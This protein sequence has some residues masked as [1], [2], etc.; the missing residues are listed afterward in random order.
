MKTKE[1]IKF[2]D[3]ENK[4][5]SEKLGFHNV[6][7]FSRAFSAIAGM[8]PGKWKINAKNEICEDIIFDPNFQNIL[9]ITSNSLN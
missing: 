4:E 5:I 9:R 2:S 6:H 7:Q 8:P 1:L 3:L